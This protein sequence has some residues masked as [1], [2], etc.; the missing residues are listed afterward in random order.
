M[1]K[2]TRGLGQNCQRFRVKATLSQIFRFRAGISQLLWL[3]YTFPCQPKMLHYTL[4]H[5]SGINLKRSVSVF[6]FQ[7][8]FFFFIFLFF[9][10]LSPALLFSQSFYFIQFQFHPSFTL[11]ISVD[12]SNSTSFIVSFL[13]VCLF[14]LRLQCR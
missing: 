1:L 6:F 3:S 7:L 9:I 13:C 4:C 14:L 5:I 2:N 8:P 11:F 10:K 12:T